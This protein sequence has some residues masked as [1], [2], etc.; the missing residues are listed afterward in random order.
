MGSRRAFEKNPGNSD[1]S[2]AV[3]A[4][5]LKA[6]T[7]ISASARG[8][9]LLALCYAHDICLPVHTRSSE[10]RS[11]LTRP[12]QNSRALAGLEGLAVEHARSRLIRL[13]CS[14]LGFNRV[15]LH[16]TAL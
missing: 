2:R 9:N 10:W 12:W 8:Q 6:R 15:L 11:A 3:N 5:H 13:A 14:A 7:E 16:S 1:E 4:T